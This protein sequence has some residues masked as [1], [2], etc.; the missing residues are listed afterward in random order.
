MA[1][2]AINK[3]LN[4]VLPVDT[5]SG[6]IWVHSVPISKE[7]FDSNYLL[8]TKTLAFLYAN[9]VGPAFGPRIA[10][11]ALIDVAKEMDDETDI[12]SN[13]LN[14]IYRI[15]NVLM[16]T[17]NGPWQTVPL[18]EVKTK[19]LVDE[20]L[21]AEVENAIVYF[22]VASAVH[23]RSEL[24]IALQGLKTNWNAETT[25]LNVT[26]YGNSLT[27]ST[28]TGTIGEKPRETPKV[29]VLKGSSIPS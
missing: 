13:L 17:P 21:I 10:K 22:T 4:L 28:Q 14:E 7:I 15:T 29:A 9:G 19:K 6:R 2:I 20:Q 23:L 27:T 11:M 1:T 12:S 3:K 18:Y 25:S 26:E 16:P 5:D 24:Q 8:L